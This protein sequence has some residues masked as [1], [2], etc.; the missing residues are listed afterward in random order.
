MENISLL[1]LTVIET[2]HE[3]CRVQA[4]GRIKAC[5]IS[6]Q[7][8]EAATA[9]GMSQSWT[10]WTTDPTYAGETAPAS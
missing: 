7:E 5:A 4:R 6:L 8:G 1:I 2:Q 10:D 3:C 9:Q